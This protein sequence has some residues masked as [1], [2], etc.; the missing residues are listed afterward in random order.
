MTP[1]AV[2][3]DGE[4]KDEACTHD[5][6]TE[7]ET[8]KCFGRGIKRHKVFKYDERKQC[9]GKSVAERGR[10][11]PILPHELEMSSRNVIQQ[12]LARTKHTETSC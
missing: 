6:N 1:Q 8:V 4:D 5:G 10:G 2:G 9:T 7:I 3:S 11:N 12:L